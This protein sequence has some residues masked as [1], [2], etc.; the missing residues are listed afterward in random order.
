VIFQNEIE[1]GAGVIL[2]M[3]YYLVM[4]FWTNVTAKKA[5]NKALAEYSFG[6][7]FSSQV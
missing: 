6:E 5:I 4:D 7:W 2:T 1:D 3:L